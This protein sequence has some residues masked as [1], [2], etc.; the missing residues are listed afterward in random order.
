MVRVGGRY[1]CVI[2]LL[3]RVISECFRDEV[4]DE[5]LYKSTFFTVLVYS[6]IL[7]DCTFWISL[8]LSKK[9]GL[10]KS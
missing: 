6:H 4:H 7:G 8:S 10:S 5:A 2:P 3:S 1:N 9:F